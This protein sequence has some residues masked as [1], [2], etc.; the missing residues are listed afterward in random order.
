[1]HDDVCSMIQKPFSP[2]IRREVWYQVGKCKSSH[3]C[4]STGGLCGRPS[5]NTRNIKM[6]CIRH[7]GDSTYEDTST[8]LSSR[9]FTT[10]TL[11]LAI[12]VDLIVFENRHLDLLAFVLDLFGSLKAIYRTSTFGSTESECTAYIVGLLLALLGTTTKAEH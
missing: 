1:M 7:G 11:D 2:F 5:E 10:Q 8:T 12:R 6:Q 9:T 4:R 3:T